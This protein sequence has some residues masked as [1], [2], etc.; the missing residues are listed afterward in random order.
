[1]VD[2]FDDGGL[3]APDGLRVGFVFVSTVLVGSE[4]GALFGRFGAGV[5][6]EGVAGAAA[7][8][9]VLKSPV[10]VLFGVGLLAAAPDG[11]STVP[12]ARRP[13]EDLSLGVIAFFLPSFEDLEVASVVSDFFGSSSAFL[14]LASPWLGFFA[15]S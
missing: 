14:S 15:V 7:G 9:I 12:S 1:M 5:R 8:A 6:F 10:F 11:R 3:P 2:V 13:S 4:A